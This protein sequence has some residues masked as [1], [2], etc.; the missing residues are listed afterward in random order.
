MLAIAVGVSAFIVLSLLVLHIGLRRQLQKLQ[1][2]SA[3]ME[4]EIRQLREQ[5]TATD[6]ATLEV[7][8]LFDEVNH[9]EDTSPYAKAI[10]L[11][12]QG[13]GADAVAAQCG[14]SR[15]EADLIISLYKSNAG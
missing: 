8:A 10:Q 13:Y 11:V 9:P 5:M 12:N 4:A 15:G 14:I 2:R 6:L 7:N 3:N 1:A